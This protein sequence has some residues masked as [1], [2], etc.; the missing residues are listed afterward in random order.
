M[1]P[2][3]RLASA[4]SDGGPRWAPPPPY[5]RVHSQSRRHAA[6]TPMDV[7]QV[8]ATKWGQE[9]YKEGTRRARHR[10]PPKPKQPKNRGRPPRAPHRRGGRASSRATRRKSSPARGFSLAS[11]TTPPPSDAV[12]GTP[13]TEV[14]E[15]GV[16][17]VGRV[18]VTA[19]PSGFTPGLWWW[20][21]TDTPTGSVTARC[22]GGRGGHEARHGRPHPPCEL[23]FRAAETWS[24]A[25]PA[26]GA[27]EDCG[28]GGGRAER[29]PPATAAGG[30]PDGAVNVDDEQPR[31]GAPAG[32][33]P[34]AL[35][36]PP[37]RVARSWAGPR[38]GRVGGSGPG[39][40][41]GHK[42]ASRE[43][44]PLAS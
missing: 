7:R 35:G 13:L 8:P 15:G 25:Q 3:P 36:T 12:A 5:T 38:P 10:P 16:A 23:G 29:G 28:T 41:H 32:M 6:A 18:V 39:R 24:P 40:W 37:H 27:T 9:C 43:G 22:R 17:V 11:P 34:S 31:G 33:P 42:G 2:L 4:R 20:S 30:C 19:R 1:E 21:T 26:R 44:Q 14:G